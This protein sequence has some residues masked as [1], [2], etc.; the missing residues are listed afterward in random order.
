MNKHVALLTN[1]QLVPYYAYRLADNSLHLDN[2]HRYKQTIIFNK[3]MYDIHCRKRYLIFQTLLRGVPL[4]SIPNW[5]KT[6]LKNR[7][8]LSVKEENYS[9]RSTGV[10][11]S[12][13]VIENIL[14]TALSKGATC[15]CTKV[16]NMT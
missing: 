11:R 4:H 10:N 1:F 3:K 8:L 16:K 15:V 14:D 13:F 6:T 9:Y 2:T 5:T 7:K 12:G